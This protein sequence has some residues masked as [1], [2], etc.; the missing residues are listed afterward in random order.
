MSQSSENPQIFTAM[1]P[2]LKYKIMSH[3]NIINQLSATLEQLNRE[4]F[5]QEGFEHVNTP[6]PYPHRADCKYNKENFSV[7][8]ETGNCKTMLAEELRKKYLARQNDSKEEILSLKNQILQKN[9]AISTINNQ[10]NNKN[11]FRTGGGAYGGHSMYGPE[12]Y[13][14]ILENNKTD[15]N[16]LQMKLTNITSPSYELK[17]LET[18]LTN[19]I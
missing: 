1:I 7:E 9:N 11:T 13:K 5:A 15:L 3:E 10:I 14:Q 12:Y 16:Q 6:Q 2:Q 18:E 4:G 17:Q 19:L 8:S